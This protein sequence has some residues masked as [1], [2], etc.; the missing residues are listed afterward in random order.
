VKK[1]TEQRDLLKIMDPRSDEEKA[2]ADELKAHMLVP[3]PA[4]GENIAR[5]QVS[6]KT[7][8]FL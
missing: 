1:R 2:A 8:Y 3:G 4:Q 5:V 6:A 7:Y